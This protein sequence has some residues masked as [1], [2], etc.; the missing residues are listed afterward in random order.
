MFIFRLLLLCWKL[1]HRFVHSKIKLQ[2]ELQQLNDLLS[3]VWLSNHYFDVNRFESFLK[4]SEDSSFIKVQSVVL[5][6]TF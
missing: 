4:K 5:E 1:G 2:L 6:K 3:T